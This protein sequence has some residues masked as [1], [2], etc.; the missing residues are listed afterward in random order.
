MDNDHT[1]LTESS[2]LTRRQMLIGTG[3]MAA[4]YAV[5]QLA[6][7]TTEAGAAERLVIPDDF[8]WVDL[9]DPDGA[10]AA[11]VEAFAMYAGSLALYG[12]KSGAS[13]G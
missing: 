7:G 9:G 11:A 4:T 1:L 6:I 2:G 8:P 13:S 3:A 12:Y 5:G 10:G